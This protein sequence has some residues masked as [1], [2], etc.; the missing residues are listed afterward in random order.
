MWEEAEAR[1]AME[2]LV[3]ETN[4]GII[5][6]YSWGAADS[7][8]KPTST[9]PLITIPNW[10][11][12]YTKLVGTHVTVENHLGDKRFSVYWGAPVGHGGSANDMEK[13]LP[14]MDELLMA[15]RKSEPASL[16]KWRFQWIDENKGP[17]CWWMKQEKIR[18]T[19]KDTLKVYL[20]DGFPH[21]V[22]E[23]AAEQL[24]AHKKEEEDQAYGRVPRI[25]EQYIIN[26]W[27][28]LEPEYEITKHQ[29]VHHL[30]NYGPD[31]LAERKS[32]GDC[33]KVIEQHHDYYHSP[34]DEN[35]VKWWEKQ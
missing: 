15:I 30:Y 6:W 9:D 29:V 17:E 31:E 5:K 32:L 12:Y 1:R 25:R 20:E 35:K 21:C 8:E 19:V 16:P 3:D 7:S 13:E 11:V 33:F 34:P 2:K 22:G 28:Q 26:V 18:H 4:R 23:D 10:T 24:A 14:L 27:E